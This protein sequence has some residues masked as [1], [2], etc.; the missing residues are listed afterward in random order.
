MKTEKLLLVD[1]HAFAYRAFF[2]IR[3]LS[4][5]AGAPTNALYGFVKMLAKMRAATGPTHLAV[6][7]DGGLAAE[8]LAALPGYKAQRPAMPDDLRRQMD[9]LAAWVGAAGGASLCRDGVEA[10]DWIATLARQAGECP[11]VIAS[12]DKDFMQLVSPR[13]GLLNPNDKSEAV[14][15]AEQVR[16][17]SG[18]EPAQIVD[19][20]ALIGDAVDNIPGVPGVGPKTATDLLRQFGSVE[21]LLARLPEVKSD[22]LR[23]NLLAS[24]DILRRNRDLIRLHDDLPLETPFEQLRVR[25]ADTVRLREFYARWGF[26]SLLL[27]LGPAAAA[28]GSLF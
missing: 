24:M 16:A 15:T 14:W 5:P 23:A 7:W 10:D 12:S 22:R 8:R 13:V 11:V 26:K 27:E 25:P 1:G 4:S 20:L 9:D 19:W 28:Q 17:K 6:V 21:A 3:S 2:A 18:V